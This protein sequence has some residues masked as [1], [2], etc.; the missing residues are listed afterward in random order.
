MP[1]FK[2]GDKVKVREDSNLPARGRTGTIDEDVHKGSL[3]YKVRLDSKESRTV[4]FFLEKDL[5]PAGP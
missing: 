2:K 5:K 3:Y 1:K 4:Y